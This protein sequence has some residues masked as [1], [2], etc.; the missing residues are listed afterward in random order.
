[1]D[2]E[3][4]YLSGYSADTIMDS[5]AINVLW[6]YFEKNYNNTSLNI[7]QMISKTFSETAQ[8]IMS[9]PTNIWDLAK[10]F[11]GIIGIVAVVFIIYKII[12]DKHRREKEKEDFTKEILNTSFTP[13][14]NDTSKPEDK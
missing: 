8:L 4:R 1:M 2:G 13:I 7:E 9:R 6:G 5:E 10:V 3:F 11:V 14:G 12:K